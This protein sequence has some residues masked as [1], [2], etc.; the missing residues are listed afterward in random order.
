M[1]LYVR[2]YL[3]KSEEPDSEEIVRAVG[4]DDVLGA[5]YCLLETCVY[6]RVQVMWMII[7]AFARADYSKNLGV[8]WVKNLTSWKMEGKR[9]FIHILSDSTGAILAM[10]LTPAT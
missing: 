3:I 8:R 4:E 9:A 5:F 10:I 6:V 7:G 2:V 1:K